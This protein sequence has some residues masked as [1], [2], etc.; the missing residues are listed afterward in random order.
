[1]PYFLE[2]RNTIDASIFRQV[3]RK[4]YYYKLA[5]R[6]GLNIELLE[7]IVALLAAGEMLPEKNRDHTLTGSWG[8]TPGVSHPFGLAH[9][10][11]DDVLVL[12][13]TSTGSHSN[14]F[15]A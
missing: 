11:E 9:R 7:H 12:T 1:M 8:R 6:R 3:K 4:F 14:S 5:I 2:Y 13:L 10:I 15:V